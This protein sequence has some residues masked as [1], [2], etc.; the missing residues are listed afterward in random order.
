[1]S[2]YIADVAL[3][4]HNNLV[5]EPIEYK[6]QSYIAQQMRRRRD[7]NG[8]IDGPSTRVASIMR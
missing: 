5:R 8:T 4:Y 6:S 3:K 7:A 2:H 1:M